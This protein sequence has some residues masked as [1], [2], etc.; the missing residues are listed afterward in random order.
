MQEA[1]LRIILASLTNSIISV[2]RFIG[3]SVYRFINPYLF[4][5]R[6]SYPSTGGIYHTGS[7]SY[8][9]APKA[10]V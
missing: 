2:Y 6:L 3:L 8:V 9:P 1:M 4:Q 7:M 5:S 10:S